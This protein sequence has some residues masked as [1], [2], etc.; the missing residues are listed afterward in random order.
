M[1]GLKLYGVTLSQTNKH[2]SGIAHGLTWLDMEISE[3]VDKCGR[4]KY[5]ESAAARR[6]LSEIDGILKFLRLSHIINSGE[7]QMICNQMMKAV[8]PTEERE[9]DEV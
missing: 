3:F 5:K 2:Q 7:Y 8:F 4:E 9:H 1:R 6:K